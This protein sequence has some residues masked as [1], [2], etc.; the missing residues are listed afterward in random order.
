MH[1]FMQNP[2]NLSIWHRGIDLAVR[3]N[4]IAARVSGVNAPGLANQLRRASSSILANIAEGAGQSTPAQC[5]RFISMAIGSAFELESHLALVARLHRTIPDLDN[6][7]DEVQ[8][9]RKMMYAYRKH[10]LKRADPSFTP[11]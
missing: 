11:Q 6:C 8:Q 9:L 5:A 1:V 4:A 7:V 3:I 10:Q 2:A